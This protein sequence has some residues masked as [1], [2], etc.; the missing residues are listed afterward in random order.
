MHLER[1]SWVLYIRGMTDVLAHMTGT[2]WKI[3]CTAGQKIAAGDT[4]VILESMKMELPVEAT[5]AGTV[6]VIHVTEG[7]AVAEGDRLVSLA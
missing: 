4:L 2:V 7:Q 3:T 1:A 5:A 6:S